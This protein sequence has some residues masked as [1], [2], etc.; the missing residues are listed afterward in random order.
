MGGPTSAFKQPTSI[1]KP[2]ALIGRASTELGHNQH[3]FGNLVIVN[4]LKS[5]LN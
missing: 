1:I 2:S 5:C 3:L 4:A